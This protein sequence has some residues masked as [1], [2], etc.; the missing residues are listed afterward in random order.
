MVAEDLL[1]IGRAAA[2]VGVATHVLRHWEAAGVLT[3]S[4]TA[5]GHRVF[6]PKDLAQI[7]LVQRG[8]AGGL[9]LDQLRSILHNTGAARREVLAAHHEA[10]RLRAA[11][12]AAAINLVEHA[13]T[14]RGPSLAECAGCRATL[15]PPQ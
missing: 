4:R 13:M 6:G 2:A 11:E 12:V 1:T 14:C 15:D 7:R 5:H 10:L 9:S 3:P 8:Q